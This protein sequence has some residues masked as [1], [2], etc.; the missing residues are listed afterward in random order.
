MMP[1]TISSPSRDYFTI[2]EL[3]TRWKTSLNELLEHGKRKDLE[4]RLNW[5]Q[6]REREYNKTCI[7]D[8]TDLAQISW[9]KGRYDIAVSAESYGS[10]TV[11]PIVLTHGATETNDFALS[12]TPLPVG[13]VVAEII[14]DDE[15]LVS[16]GAAAPEPIMEWL[17]YGDGT[18]VDNW[19]LGAGIAF[20]TAINF[21]PVD[22]IDLDGTSLT[23]FA[24]YNFNADNFPDQENQFVLPQLS[25][26]L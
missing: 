16:W 24:I 9:S 2:K 22:L 1:I 6:L 19:W 13:D 23:K 20:S 11:G 7:H 4:I 18:H 8:E 14:S 17:M 12:E 26:V 15:V 10:Q 25:H 3:L 5:S 21:D